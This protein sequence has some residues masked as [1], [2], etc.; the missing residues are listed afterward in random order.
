MLAFM[1]ICVVP[2][3]TIATLSGS[4]TH[5][6]LSLSNIITEATLYYSGSG[7]S[8]FDLSSEYLRGAI[9]YLGNGDGMVTASEVDDF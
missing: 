5:T 4:E 7:G 2:T 6:F 8:G 3:N 1:R 9:D